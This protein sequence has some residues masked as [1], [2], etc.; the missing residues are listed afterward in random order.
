MAQQLGRLGSDSSRG[1]LKSKQGVGLSPH[2]TPTPRVPLTLTTAV[3]GRMGVYYVKKLSKYVKNN[4][5][6]DVWLRPNFEARRKRTSRI[7]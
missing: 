1:K 7:V 6:M 5:E 2:P 4:T 3:S